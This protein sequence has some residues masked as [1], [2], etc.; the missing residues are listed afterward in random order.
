[1]E[2]VALIVATIPVQASVLC[3]V[4]VVVRAAVTILAL[5]D[6]LLVWVNVRLGVAMAALELVSQTVQVILNIQHTSNI[7]R[8]C[9][10]HELGFT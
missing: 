5:R 4:M 1:M 8:S 10:R 7:F 2:V 9:A 3:C 6:V